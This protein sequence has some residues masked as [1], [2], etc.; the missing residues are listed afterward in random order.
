VPGDRPAFGVFTR[1]LAFQRWEHSPVTGR[2]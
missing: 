2:D 1:E